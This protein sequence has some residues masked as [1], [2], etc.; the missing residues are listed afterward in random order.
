[1]QTLFVLEHNAICDR[2]RAEYP[3]WSDD[4]L[5]DRGLDEILG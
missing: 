5:F 1:M 3:S 4:E 2:L